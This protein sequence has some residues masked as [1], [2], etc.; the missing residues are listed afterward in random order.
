MSYLRGPLSRDQ[1][2]ALKSGHVAAG[3]D[4]SARS[5][6]VDRSAPVHA[7][8]APVPTRAATRESPSAGRVQ[9]TRPV[10]PP[11]VEQFF[12]PTSDPAPVY[13]PVILGAARVSF[14]DTKLKI[15]ESR[16]VLFAAPITAGPVPVDWQ[17]AAPVACAVRALTHEPAAAEA[18]FAEIPQVALK[19]KSYPAWQKAF[20]Q[21]LAHTQRVEL[22]RHAPTKLTSH[23]DES[24]RDFTARVHDALRAGRDA[25]VASLRKK[26]AAKRH[27][28]TEKIRKAEA[29][30]VREQEQA[31]QQKTQTMLSAGAAVIGA[32]FGRKAASTGTLGRATTAARGVGRS[33]KEAKDVQQAQE[34]V[35]ALQQQ[36]ETFD[37]TVEQETQAIT[38]RFDTPIEFETISMTPKR[39]QV[40]VQFVALGWDPR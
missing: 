12:I 40:S 19:P 23:A 30:V 33:V 10:M 36:L 26:Y 39:G 25:D 11:G 14:S 38:E 37:E 29:A 21:W 20:S 8:P 5:G 2:R 4:A 18:R 28:L 7:E 27:A 35:R 13:T 1:I 17:M 24:D 15:N 16:D 6:G 3:A 9:P 31:S 34:N 32:L 22:K